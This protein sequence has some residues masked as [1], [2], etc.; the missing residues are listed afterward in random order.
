MHQFLKTVDMDLGRSLRQALAK[1]TGE[2]IAD[3]KAVKALCRDLQR[4][5]ITSDVNV[6]LVFELTKKIEA[7]ALDSKLPPGLSLREHV[8]KVVYEELAAMMGERYEPKISPKKILLLGLFGSGKCVHPH[9]KIPLPDG[10]TRAIEDIYNSAPQAEEECEGGFLKTGASIDIFSFDPGTLKIRK[11]TGTAIW[12]LKKTE[13]LV[14]ISVDNGNSEKIST[15]PEHPFFILENGAIKQRRADQLK[16][17]DFIAM[18]GQLPY[19]TKQAHF[20]FIGHL[21]PA[22]RIVNA[23]LARKLKEFAKSRFGTLRS[24]SKTLLP[25]RPYCRI[26]AELKKG[27]ADCHFLA[28]AIGI[29]FKHDL[30]E[31]VVLRGGKMC[32]TFPTRL[33]AELAEFMGYVYGDGNIESG[34]VHVTNEDIEIVER[35]VFL[36]KKLFGITPATLHDKRSKV[37][38]RR[39]SLFSKTL[40]S[41]ICAV[42]ELPCGKKSTSMHLPPFFLTADALS[43][44]A[45]LRAYFDCDGYVEEGARHIEF[46]SASKEFAYQLRALLLS[47][48]ITSAYST[49][50]AEG[51]HYYR[52]FLRA[53]EAEAFAIKAGS[54]V[55]KKSRRLALLA[56]IGEGQTDGKLE[57]LH[58]GKAL[59]EAREYFGASIGEVQKKV[60][61]YGI[62]ESEGIISRRKLAEFLKVLKSSSNFH[63]TI[64]WACASPTD[65]GRLRQRT[66]IN[67]PHLNA[68]VWRLQQQGYLEGDESGA[69]QTT[70]SGTMLLS[71]NKKFDPYKLEFLESLSTSDIRWGKVCTVEFDEGEKYVYDLTVE[72]CHNFVA[73]NFIVHN[74]TVC[75]KLAHFYK[76]RGLS[77]ALVACDTDRPAAYQQLQ[78]L[79]RQT[80]AAFYGIEGERDVRKILDKAKSEA[81]EDVVVVDSAGRSAFDPSLIEQLKLI[82]SEISPDERFLVI[83]ADI[84]QVAGKQASQFHEAVGLSGVIITKLDGSGK[85]GGAL[86]A[87]SS[88]KAK[89]AFIGT[90]EKMDA[91][92]PFDAQKFVGRLLGFPDIGALLE[93]VKK[94]AEEQKMPEDIGEKLTLRAFYEQLRAAKKLGPLSGVFSML[95]AADMPQDMVNTSEKKLKKFEVII[96][97]MTP[98]ERE[99]ASLLKKSRT[100]VERIAKGSGTS[101]EDVRELLTQFEK[102]S[103]MFSQFKKNRGFRKRMEKMMK[104]SNIDFSKLQGAS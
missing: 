91:L 49:K 40:V 47:E 43:K 95:G 57:N 15:T 1:F 60:S 9:T 55:G 34:A 97:S 42:F 92:E 7:R 59:R 10:S 65:F 66:S 80:G 22:T 28:K 20:N 88:S 94:I 96:S 26:S 3:E 104:G 73:N 12:K 51:S 33:N 29:G 11:A 54:S 38:L 83:S 39:V 19:E 48:S 32:I 35:L 44:R 58:I 86:S 90:G 2:P 70:N 25:A 103:G 37:A 72:G 36:S 21:T 64:L 78:Q 61:S 23:K 87:V 30:D 85:G 24:A 5:L 89:V 71:Q 46:C 16:L 79:S 18:P 76:S 53:K 102:V 69:L 17:G 4:V 14:S 50:R 77:V 56:G 13:P 81:K 6:R 101:P 82:N 31:Q 63:N 75:G 52:V 67:T 98:A 74:T 41:S 99:D 84:G 62:Y 45:F 27:E 8:V 68:S 100:R 93:K